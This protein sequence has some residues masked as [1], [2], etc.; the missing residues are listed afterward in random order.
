MKT[1]KFFNV[2][3]EFQNQDHTLGRNVLESWLQFFFSTNLKGKELAE[4]VGTKT[5]KLVTLNQSHKVDNPNW[6]EDCFAVK[7]IA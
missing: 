1:Q 6:W 3:F 4:L 7:Q 5:V 2:T